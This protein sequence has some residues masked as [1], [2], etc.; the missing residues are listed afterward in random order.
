M[1][2]TT[3]SVEVLGVPLEIEYIPEYGDLLFTES[4]NSV[5]LFLYRYHTFGE[6]RFP[7]DRP[8]SL[9]FDR[10]SVGDEVTLS[11][12][13]DGKKESVTVKIIEDDFQID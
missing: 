5:E 3:K 7:D 6:W 9:L 12:D 11:L 4:T 8:L 13:V 1:V 2:K 10:L